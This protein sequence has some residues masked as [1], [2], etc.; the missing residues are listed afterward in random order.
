MNGTFAISKKSRIVAKGIG[1]LL[2]E[3]A[4]GYI[5]V[6]LFM[7]YLFFMESFNGIKHFIVGAVVFYIVG[8]TIAWILCWILAGLGHAYLG[9]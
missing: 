2:L 8:G 3:E 6:I 4:W 9:H 1:T 7:I 5:A